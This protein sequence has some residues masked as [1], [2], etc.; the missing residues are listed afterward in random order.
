MAAMSVSTIKK[1][2]LVSALAATIYIVIAIAFA[3]NA[4]PAIT[5][6]TCMWTNGRG[7]YVFT[8]PAAPSF[9][10]YFARD[11]GAFHRARRIN[12]KLRC[13]RRF[14]VSIPTPNHVVIQ[15]LYGRKGVCKP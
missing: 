7:T 5:T 6:T 1:A 10:K 13:S 2:I 14:Y 4:L 3:A 9:C 11:P 8:G 15:K 12:G